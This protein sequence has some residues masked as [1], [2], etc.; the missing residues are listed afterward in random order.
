MAGKAEYRV[1]NWR[2]YN[3]AL[4]QRCNITLW[5]PNDAVAAWSAKP[6]G[7]PGNP[8]TYSDAA[9]ECAL[10]IRALFRLPLRS[11]VGLLKS[12]FRLQ[13]LEVNVPHYSTLS[14]RAANLEVDLASLSRQ[15]PIHLALDS[16]GLKVFGEGEWKVR[17]HGADK[18][19]V[20]RKY[21]IGLDVGTREIITHELTESGV[22]DSTVTENLIPQGKRVHAIYADGAYDNKNAYDAIA[23]VGATAK[24]PPRSGAALTPRS[25]KVT[26]GTVLRDANV[27]E[28]WRLG[29]ARWKV[30]SGY[31]QRSLAENAMYRMK[32]IFGGSLNSR[33]I[34][35]QKTE[36]AI[37]TRALNKMTQMGMPKSFK[38]TW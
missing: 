15:G 14:R 36:I 25:T 13:G 3:R 8:F 18:R 34:Q 30:D 33:K 23:K 12:L 37:K 26:P 2:D 10:T 20:W 29:R 38:R 11:T 24:V 22:H 16:T 7:A 28:V 9:I 31:H 27:R 4:E 17:M 21:H 1:S 5:L 32:T 19:R 35:R 6:T